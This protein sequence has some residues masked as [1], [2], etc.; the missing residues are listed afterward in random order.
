M[1][2]ETALGRSFHHW[3]AMNKNSLDCDLLLLREGKDNRR[4]AEERRGQEA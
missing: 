1:V 4:S 3:G 2:G